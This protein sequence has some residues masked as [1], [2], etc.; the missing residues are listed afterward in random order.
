[1]QQSKQRYNEI[2]QAN[3][4]VGGDSD[5]GRRSTAQIEDW[6]NTKLEGRLLT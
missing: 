2:L 4:D 3:D 6:V 5:E 1:M